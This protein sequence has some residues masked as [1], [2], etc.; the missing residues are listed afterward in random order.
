[1]ADHDSASASQSEIPEFQPEFQA[2][3]LEVDPQKPPKRVQAAAGLSS[4]SSQLRYGKR[5]KSRPTLSPMLLSGFS[6]MASRARFDA[7]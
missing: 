6:S 4:C 7:A 2:A 5:N 1:M 3:L